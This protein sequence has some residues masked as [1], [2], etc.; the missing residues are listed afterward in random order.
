[1]VLTLNS[2]EEA[3]HLGSLSLMLTLHRHGQETASVKG[4]AE[5]DESQQE[6]Q[7]EDAS[8]QDEADR[9]G[10]ELFES[11]VDTVG[12]T[13]REGAMLRAQGFEDPHFLV[14]AAPVLSPEDFSVR[15]GPRLLS[16]L[17]ALHEM[18]HRGYD[19]CGRKSPEDLAPQLLAQPVCSFES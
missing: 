7:E 9:E 16:H 19:L 5:K 3:I 2:K 15:D 12:L 4:D 17:Q 14:E 8:A 1:M 6:E 11:W 13:G 18:D 10:T